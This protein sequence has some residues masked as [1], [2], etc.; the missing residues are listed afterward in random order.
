[1]GSYDHA[2]EIVIDPVLAYSTHLGGSSDDA[3]LGIAVDGKGAA[4]VTGETASA[5]FPL[6]DPVQG[7]YEGS[8]DVF[9]TKIDPTGAAYLY[10]TY[11]GGSSRDIGN[12]IAV[13]ISGVAYMTGQIFSTDFPLM[14]PVQ[15][16]NGGSSDAFI[17][18]I[19][20]TVPLPVIDLVITPDAVTV[21]EGGTPGYTLR[22]TNTTVEM[23]C[24][25]YWENITMPGGGTYPPVGELF[26]P[27]HLCLNDSQSVHL[28]HGVPITTPLGTYVLNGYVGAYYFPELTVIVDEDHFN[29]DIVAPV[30]PLS[31]RPHTSWS[32]IENGFIK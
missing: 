9:I 17:S 29:F 26:G 18:K 20:G 30:A 24:F 4:Y 22:A 11:L 28:T 27:V 21:S 14:N 6:M 10:S 19:S 25:N 13:D 2:R 5:D 1:M 15:A 23:Q 31:A 7:I 8:G 3:G 16:T 12:G 32:L